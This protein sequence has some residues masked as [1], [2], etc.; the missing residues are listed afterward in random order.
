MTQNNPRTRQRD[1]G[2]SSQSGRVISPFLGCVFGAF[3]PVV[4]VVVYDA[5]DNYKNGLPFAS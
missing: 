5:K 4:V 2:R 1:Q 3:F